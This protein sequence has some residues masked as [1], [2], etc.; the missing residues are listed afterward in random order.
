MD[1][2]GIKRVVGTVETLV[3]VGAVAVFVIV[4]VV[5]EEVVSVAT[6]C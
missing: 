5:S 4:V 6:T 2:V 3:L 1:V